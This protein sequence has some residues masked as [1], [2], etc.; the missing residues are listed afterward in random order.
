MNL[1]EIDVSEVRSSSLEIKQRTL[2]EL[3]LRRYK[4]L[5]GLILVSIELVWTP[6]KREVLQD[7][8]MRY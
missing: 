7:R 8:H 2:G 6:L 4:S 3:E 5:R 1:V